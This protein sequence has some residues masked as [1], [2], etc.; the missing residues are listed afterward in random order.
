MTGTAE[1]D[2]AGSP[3]PGLVT[4]FASTAAVVVIVGTWIVAVGAATTS[5]ADDPSGSTAR[6]G[7]STSM[8]AATGADAPPLQLDDS[9]GVASEHEH[10][11]GY[12]A[13]PGDETPIVS[14]YDSR[15]SADQRETARRLIDE[16]REGMERYPDVDSVLADGYVSIGDGSTGWEHFVHPEYMEDDHDLDP[17]RIESIVARVRPDGSREIVSAMYILGPDATMDDVPDIAGS[18]TTWHDHQD[19]CWSAHR[20]VGRVTPDGSCR[21]GEFRGTPPMLHVWMVPHPCGPF[22]GIEGHGRECGHAH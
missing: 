13:T 20:V 14:L 1:M 21:S 22:A 3:V 19:L 11:H 18:L 16:T 10:D 9:R 17:D 6:V 15:L 7:G 12:G 2:R 8:E 5:D 4:L